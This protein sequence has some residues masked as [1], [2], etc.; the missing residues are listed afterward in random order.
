[1]SGSA[2]IFQ[3]SI[4]G[5]SK[6]PQIM[7]AREEVK[8]IFE[9]ICNGTILNL[10]HTMRETIKKSVS[11]NNNWPSVNLASNPPFKILK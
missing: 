1:M 8:V 5:F 3:L 7:A 10:A 9:F 6:C 11:N 4:I 2:L